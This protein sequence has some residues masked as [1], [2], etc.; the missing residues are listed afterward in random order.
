MILT[1]C[2]ACKRKLK[3]AENLQGKQVRCPGC[4]EVFRVAAPPAEAAEAVEPAPVAVQPPPAARPAPRPAAPPAA[5]PAPRPAP[6][7]EDEYDEEP[8]RPAPR[9]RPPPEDEYDDRPEVAD[10]GDA[11]KRG[12]RTAKRGALW[13]QLA[14]LL[15]LIPYVIFVV[16]L[17]ALTGGTRGG[18]DGVVAR[19]AMVIVVAMSAV[20]LIPVIFLAV[21][22]TLLS[23]LKVRGLV[24]TACILSFVVAPQ[25]LVYGAVWFLDFL[26][27]KEVNTGAAVMMP[28][29]IAVTS[30]LGM[31]MNI[32]AGI[33]G[34]LILAKP[35]VKAAYR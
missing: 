29:A 1:N 9:R 14:F 3:L 10:V 32:V 21:G 2:P 15:D 19:G 6:P 34:L 27:A 33:L 13:L 22:A 8:V 20:Y 16:M 17:V 24:I 7:P 35:D 31:V 23:N 11:A 28:F 26:K 25:L 12:R 4:K 18:G 30:F 5:R